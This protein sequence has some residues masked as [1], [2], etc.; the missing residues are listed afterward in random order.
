MMSDRA[1]PAEA[2]TRWAESEDPDAFELGTDGPRVIVVGLD[3]SQI[4]GE[5]SH[6]SL[7]AAAYAAGL[8]R[9]EGARV[10]PVWVRPPIALA[11]A[12]AATVDTLRRERD[13]REAEVRRS[14]EEAARH[15]GVAPAALVVR[16]GDPF[17]EL[18][19]VAEEVH[20]DGIVVGASRQR[21]GSLA[22]KLV[23][24]ARWPVTVVP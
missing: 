24:D 20:A 5:G 17:E 21:L 2:D 19:A 11:E 16:E 9:R 6:A 22:V 15:F 14:V 8:A 23:R 10:V 12:F 3:A 1:A 7:H 13:D 18:T 4:E